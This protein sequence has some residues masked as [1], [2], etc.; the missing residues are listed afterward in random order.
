[1]DKDG[2]IEF[3]VLGEVK[4]GGLTR[5]EATDLLKSKIAEYVKDPLVNIRITNFTISV[6]GEVNKPGSYIIQDEKVTLAE[7]LGM[8]GDLTIYGKRK[9][10]LLI[11]EIEGV[12]KFS[13]IDLTSVRSLS[14][15]TFG[16]KQNDIIY[17]EPNTAQI[18][19]SSY[20][21]NNSVLISAIGALTSVAAL[22]ITLTK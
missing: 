17:V 19:A 20:N 8:A 6:L 22:I 2:N 21:R 16:L 18:R 13:I 10:I 1:V 15:S 3:P 5:Q 9:N 7:A 12:K 14:A 11:R 4:I